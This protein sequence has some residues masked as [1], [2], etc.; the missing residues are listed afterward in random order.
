M[1]ISRILSFLATADLTPERRALVDALAT[2][3]GTRTSRAGGNGLAAGT[4]APSQT[5]PPQASAVP[6]SAVPA[7]APQAAKASAADQ[8]APH[9]A[10]TAQ[11]APVPG[12]PVPTVSAES[13]G[14][15]STFP[16]GDGSV[17]LEVPLRITIQLGPPAAPPAP[18]A[19]AVG[20]TTGP[21][22][23][24]S[25][26]P[27]GPPSATVPV[28]PAAGDGR[29]SE[30]ISIDP[31]YSNRSGYDPDFLG[32]HL[33]LPGV[34]EEHPEL[35]YH[36]FSVV[37][38][39]RRR[40][41]RVAAVNI[42]G[43]KAPEDMTRES[44]RWILDPRLPRE[45]QTGE[46]VYANNDLDRGHLV[47]RLD[48]AWGRRA[49]AANDDTFHFTNCAPQHHGFNA[50][51]DLWLGLEDYVL[52]SAQT[53]GLTVSVLSGPVL[54]DGDP[55]YR[56]VALPLQFFKLAAMR[57][58][59]GELSVTAYLLSQEALLDEFETGDEEFSF[60]AYRTFQV[61]VRRVGDL[62]G[63]DLTAY[64]AGD[65]LERLEATSLPREIVRPDDIL[66]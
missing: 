64:V 10:A 54:A 43:A 9:V 62:T 49:K 50:G 46:D 33:P 39:R 14:T 15:P 7:S 19:P 57:T 8:A 36:H 61:P 51:R 66:T 63:M 48:P 11:H 26:P 53:E 1:R 35:R 4:N 20:A 13:D 47:R 44:D 16:A 27:S 32:T 52:R 37:M 58:T 60:G 12:G 59:A 29:L 17:T 28:G 56:G 2:K 65:P 25:P 21:A 6:A 34:D 22:S 5:S 18:A 38:D 23:T 55:E 41:A 42:D 30:A 3:N 45:E 40:L 24:T 31:D